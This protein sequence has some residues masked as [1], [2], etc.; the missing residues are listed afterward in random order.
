MQI[1]VPNV[2]FDFPM[3]ELAPRPDSLRG[4]VV[5]FLDGWGLQRSDGGFDMYPLMSRI[6]GVLNGQ[7]KIG[8]TVWQ[9]KP[10]VSAPVPQDLLDAFVSR[11]DVVVN[12]EC[13]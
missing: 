8:G 1:L 12:G 10:S 2:T 7:Y 6:R 9:K 4:L 13:I 5:G 3:V 11:V